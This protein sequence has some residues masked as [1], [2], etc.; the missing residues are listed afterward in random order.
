MWSRPNSFETQRGLLRA[1]LMT[2]VRNEAISHCRAAVRRTRLARQMASQFERPEEVTLN[3]YLE[4]RRLQDAIASFEH[5][6]DDV[7]SQ[8]A[9][10]SGKRRPKTGRTT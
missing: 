4:K 1:F 7:R 9:G 10:H 3:D 2:R 6:Y 8:I 5:H